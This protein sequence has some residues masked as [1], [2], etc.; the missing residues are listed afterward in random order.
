MPQR[1]EINMHR[2][3]DVLAQIQRAGVGRVSCLRHHNLQALCD[4]PLTS[5]CQHMIDH[6]IVPLW[7]RTSENRVAPDVGF[8]QLAF[9]LVGS[10][11]G[12]YDSSQRSLQSW[13]AKSHRESSI[14]SF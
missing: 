12:F 2:E 9:C 7:P 3:Y 10:P 13:S 14:E 4:I 8:L 6:V 11:S 5:L 1:V